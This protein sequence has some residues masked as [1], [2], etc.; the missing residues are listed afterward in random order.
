MISIFIFIFSFSCFF[1]FIF[2]RRL[3]F[4]RHFRRRGAVQRGT[5]PRYELGRRSGGELVG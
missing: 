5:A 3:P 4:T 2:Y 1:C